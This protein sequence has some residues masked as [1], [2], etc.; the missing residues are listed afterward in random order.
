MEDGVCTKCT[1]DWH[2]HVNTGF[3]YKKYVVEEE[4]EFDNI[5]KKFEEEN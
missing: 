5:K 1:H 4:C 3:F 2:A